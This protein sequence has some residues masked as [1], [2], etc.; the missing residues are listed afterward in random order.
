VVV[1]KLRMNSSLPVC[2][3]PFNAMEWLCLDVDSVAM[4]LHKF[5][6]NLHLTYPSHRG[7]RS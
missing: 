6:K 3:A 2:L 4:S 1:V 5:I 7:Y